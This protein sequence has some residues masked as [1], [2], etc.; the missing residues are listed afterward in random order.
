MAFAIAVAGARMRPP[1]PS[2][3]ALKPYLRFQKLPGAALG[4]VRRAVEGD[5]EF[6]QRI[7][8]VVDEELAG[9][10][11]WLWLH[12]PDGWTDEVAGLVAAEQAGEAAATEERQERAASKRVEA[13]EATAR[14]A[15]GEAAALRAEL[16]GEHD[17][18]V[19]AEAL[20]SRLERKVAQLELELT[21]A[22][23]RV[24]TAEAERAAADER[25]AAADGHT[26]VAEAKAA[27]VEAQ[28]SE[29]EARARVAEAALELARRGGEAPGAVVPEGERVDLPPRGTLSVTDTGALVEALRDASAATE[30]LG[31]A[32]A[33]AAAAVGPADDACPPDHARRAARPARPPRPPRPHGGR[34]PPRRAPLPLPGGVFADTVEAATHLV[35]QPGILLIV[36]GYN[37]AKRGWPNDALAVQRERLLDALDEL[38]ARHGTAIHVV[39][40][41]ADLW[42]GPPGRRHLRIEFSPAGVTADEV[43]VEMVGSLPADRPLVVAT[44]DGEVRDGARAGG[45]NVISSEQLL[46][47]ARR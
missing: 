45:A 24:A 7:A 16:A 32:L 35:R 46:A 14:R 8:A 26:A 9:R 19:E 12:R 3:P 28:L 15:T 44:N 13:A 23:R 18:R 31:A 1:V 29:A 5:D 4:P 22:R 6:R 41:G 40:D 43:I 17:R 11:G 34:R 27:M 30:R 37:A 33:A 2:P 38:V 36:D 47:V 42:T 21:G 20:R 39:F 25:Q 10:V